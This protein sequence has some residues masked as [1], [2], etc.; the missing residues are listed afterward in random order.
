[1]S[2]KMSHEWWHPFFLFW[3]CFFPEYANKQR[4]ITSLSL[5][6]NNW[7]S[8]LTNNDYILLVS[9]LLPLLSFVSHKGCPCMERV[10]NLFLQV[11]PVTFFFPVRLKK[12]WELSHDGFE[13]IPESPRAVYTNAFRIDSEE[14]PC[15]ICGFCG[16]RNGGLFH[17]YC[18]PYTM[19]LS[20]AQTLKHRPSF[21]GSAYWF[22]CI[23][24][25]EL[26]V[27]RG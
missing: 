25:L 5:L 10:I 26:I 16:R 17:P 23:L 4:C 24:G 1:M 11:M 15:G 19:A 7:K 18:S 8:L 14:M 22:L 21:G 9:P 13:D 27:C 3:G 2:S 20:V 12:H 6:W